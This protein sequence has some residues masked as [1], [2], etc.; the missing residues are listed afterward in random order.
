MWV[1]R[2]S[3]VQGLG[4]RAA[5]RGTSIGPAV[6]LR[7]TPK[8]DCA[9][10]TWLVSACLLLLPLSCYQGRTGTVFSWLRG[11]ILSCLLWDDH[12]PLLHSWPPHSHLLS[13]ASNSDW[14]LYPPCP[15]VSLRYSLTSS[16]QKKLSDGL[17]FTFSLSPQLS[18]VLANFQPLRSSFSPVFLLFLDDDSHSLSSLC[19]AFH[20]CPCSWSLIVSHHRDLLSGALWCLQLL[21]THLWCSLIFSI[22]FS[23]RFP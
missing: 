10:S 16:F 18:Q 8:P 21:C 23:S 2:A 17:A 7:K 20:S 13:R 1:V 15:A 19:V 9:V 14:V 5:G 11:G 3:S 22:S 6:M 12:F 4:R